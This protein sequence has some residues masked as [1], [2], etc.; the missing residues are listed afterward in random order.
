[1]QY[2][3]SIDEASKLTGFGRTKLYEAI[4]SGKLAAR[5]YGKRTVILDHDLKEF[6]VSLGPYA[7]RKSNTS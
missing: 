6:L 2:S 3:Y 5:K 7:P 1:M 4:N